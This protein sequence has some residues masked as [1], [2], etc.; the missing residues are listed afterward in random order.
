[1]AVI[2]VL[3]ILIGLA[4]RRSS[5]ISNTNSSASHHSPHHMCNQ[6]KK[7][8]KKAKMANSV[9]RNNN[10]IVLDNNSSPTTT[11]I[12]ND[13]KSVTFCTNE[14]N[15]TNSTE[16][17]DL[18]ADLNRNDLKSDQTKLNNYLNT[19][20]NRLIKDKDETKINSPSTKTTRTHNR[21]SIDE[22]ELIEINN[23]HKS[24]PLFL[25]INNGTTLAA[26]RPSDLINSTTNINSTFNSSNT[27]NLNVLNPNHNSTVNT[28]LTPTVTVS[29]GTTGNSIHHYRHNQ[30]AASRR[31]VLKMLG[32]LLFS[33]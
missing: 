21:P 16:Q 5:S 19:E 20:Q 26:H 24:A 18:K 1:M 33:F 3:Y 13:S 4:L 27:N 23:N 32:K 8:N 28:A 9:Q 12:Y 14:K 10:S 30:A 6:V 31:S 11:L 7:A 25:N 22:Q 17:I 15:R 29:S 2:S